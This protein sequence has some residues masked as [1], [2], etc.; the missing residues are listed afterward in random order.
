MKAKKI[1]MLLAVLVAAGM[2]L[3]GIARAA[4]DI[5]DISL[6]DPGPGDFFLILQAAGKGFEADSDD[7]AAPGPGI[8]YT[9]DKH[10]LET[11]TLYALCDLGNNRIYFAFPQEPGGTWGMQSIPLDAQTEKSLLVKISG[12]IPIYYDTDNSQSLSTTGTFSVQFKKQDGIATSAK[13]KSLAMTYAKSI[14]TDPGNAQLLGALKMKGKMVEPYDMPAA[15]QA[16]FGL[17]L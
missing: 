13:L 12:T 11:I 3:G 2:I 10:K 16:L 4:S 9:A 8:V 6:P 15:V 1:T 14:D 5:N 7:P 17:P